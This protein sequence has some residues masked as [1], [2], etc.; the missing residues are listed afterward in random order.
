M[1]VLST[2]P[3]FNLSQNQTLQLVIG[4]TTPLSGHDSNRLIFYSPD[5]LFTFQGT[6]PFR[7]RISRLRE[8]SFCPT[9]VRAS[10]LLC[11]F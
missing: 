4:E 5:S 7:R 1:H 3:A 6:E 9:C 2:P 8:I 11:E 10:T